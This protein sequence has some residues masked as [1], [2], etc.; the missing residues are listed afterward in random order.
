M[1]DGLE[2]AKQFHE[3][4]ER[5]APEFGYETRP[6]TKAFDADSPNG[7]L[8]IA[9]CQEIGDLIQRAAFDAGFET[10]LRESR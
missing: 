9:V 5:R 6:E 8:M 10:G 7:R 3:V 1:V 2:I 4:Y